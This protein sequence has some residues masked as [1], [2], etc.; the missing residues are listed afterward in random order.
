MEL[1]FDRV[2]LAEVCNSAPL[3][4]ARWGD[5]GFEAVARR[6]GELAGIESL[7]DITYLPGARMRGDGSGMMLLGFGAS[8]VIQGITTDDAGAPVSV[9]G[10][11][12][13]TCFR[14]HEV[15]YLG[16]ENVDGALG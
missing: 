8:V 2:E 16:K 13:V 12:P 11:R 10:D 15:E 1:T 14:V 6:L 4:R 3:M 9:D 5:E 7:A